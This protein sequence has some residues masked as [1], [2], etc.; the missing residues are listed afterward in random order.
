MEK[1][2][3]TDTGS[4]DVL[5]LLHGF[6]EDLHVWEGILPELV[7]YRLVCMDLPG[8]GKSG[9]TEGKEVETLEDMA[10]RVAVTLKM[11]GI[12]KCT[13][14]GHSMGGYVALAFAEKYPEMLTGWGLFHSTAYPDSPEKKEDRL[15]QVEFVR[16]NGPVPY[17]NKLI[18]GLFSKSHERSLQTEYSLKIARECKAEGIINAL[19][20]MRQRPERIETLTNAEVPV[21]IVAGADDALIPLEKLSYQASLP[22]RCQFELL[23]NSGHMGM[24]E[25]PG[26]SVRL[27]DSFMQFARMG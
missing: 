4:G 19:L 7:R 3:Y 11:A 9:L 8:F 21:L 2:N 20:A 10:T 17:V 22:A 26:E 13:L 15:K 14:I 12:E 5:V 25:E 27:L 16:K 1:L 23:E 6:C 18:P 24:T